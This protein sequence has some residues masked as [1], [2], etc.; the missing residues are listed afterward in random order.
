MKSIVIIA[1]AVLAG[2]AIGVGVSYFILF[3]PAPPEPPPEA[4]APAVP[5]TGPE[6]TQAPAFTAPPSIEE[7]IPAISEAIADVSTSNQSKEVTLVVTER[8]ANEQAIIFLSNVEIPENIPL[9]IT[10]VHL[11]FKTGN[12]V[13]VDVE[14]T[15]LGFGI[16]IAVA[17]RVSVEAGKPA[18]EVTEVN[19]GFVPVP[20]TAKQQ[21]TD[22]IRQQSE[23]LYDQ[24]IESELGPDRQ[25]DLEFKEIVIEE[26][27]AT[28]TAI[29]TPKD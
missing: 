20:S 27:S 10:A 14:T 29:I 26:E 2:I 18:V 9:E 25:V 13:L 4:V 21:I 7:Q 22:F 1:I 5:P 6:S 19:F 17:S 8:E 24:L 15:G 23:D 12:N 16:T 11:D 28:V 3:P